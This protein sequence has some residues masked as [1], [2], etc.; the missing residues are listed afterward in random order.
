M[1][2]R[3]WL[4]FE[5]VE[6]G[7]GNVTRARRLGEVGEAT[8]MPR[9]TLI[10]K[11]VGF[12]RRSCA[13]RNIFSVSGSRSAPAGRLV[14]L[15]IEADDPHVEGRRAPGYAG[16]DAAEA[17]HSRGLARQDADLVSTAGCVANS[18]KMYRS[19]PAIGAW[20]QRGRP[21]TLSSRGVIVS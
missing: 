15:G 19:R 9:P 5:H 12:L 1:V 2:R 3:Q 10:R 13:R 14:D 7:A 21:A 6:P 18:G 11:A 20:I 17:D 8:M 4:D 16:P